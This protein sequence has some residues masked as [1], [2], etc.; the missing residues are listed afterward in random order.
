M[1]QATDY[2][3]LPPSDRED[4]SNGELE[5]VTFVMED[6]ETECEEKK[7]KW[8]KYRIAKSGQKFC[9]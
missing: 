4:T 2:T 9:E 8:T 6:K 7:S 3:K 5:H 1:T